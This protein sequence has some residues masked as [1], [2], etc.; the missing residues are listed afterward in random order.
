MQKLMQKLLSTEAGAE[1]D[2]CRPVR[3][4][5]PQDISQRP[6]ARGEDALEPLS[7]WAMLQELALCRRLRRFAAPVAVIKH[8]WGN[9][10]VPH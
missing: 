2:G 5:L 1:A 3:M 8:V 6:A 9:V 4:Q 10:E 7:V